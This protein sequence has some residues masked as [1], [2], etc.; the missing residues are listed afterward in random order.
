M[1]SINT[2]SNP[3]ESRQAGKDLRKTV[4]RKSHG[5]WQPSK[6]RTDP[7]TLIHD[8]EATRLKDLL[9][10]RHE[11]MSISAFTFYRGAALLM[12]SDLATTQSTGI[13]CQICGDA[14]IANF[15]GFG[16]PER[17]LIYDINDF[18]ET[19]AGPWEWDV[20]RFATSI[21]ICGR[22]RGFSASKRTAIVE[23][24]VKKYRE[25]MLE[26]AQMN[27]ID[28]WYAHL[29]VINVLAT[30]N[31][32][33]K[34][35]EGKQLGKTLSK[36]FGKTSERAVEKLTTVENG[37]RHIVSQPPLI[38]PLAELYPTAKADKIEEG[39]RNLLKSYKKSLPADRR[40]LI[41]GYHLSDIGRK[42]V[43]VGSV[44]TRAWI[45][46]FTG[47]D[48]N[49]PLVLQIKEAD[50]S[51]L[52]AYQHTSPY[53]NHGQRVVEGQRLMQA[54][55]D[56]LL[57]W[58]RGNNIS[59]ETNDFYVRQLWD[60]KTSTNLD[61]ITERELRAMASMSA[62][63]LA[64]A[65][66]RSGNRFAIAG[67]LGKSSSFDEALGKFARTYADL[68]EQDYQRFVDSLK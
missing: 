27:T 59:N 67:Y 44:G 11:R 61:T 62:W 4:S 14:H 64:R 16:S 40:C 46:V 68:N 26:F 2:L 47:R 6:D 54:S 29:D 19:L 45:A 43:G 10:I 18:D 65:H 39:V 63:T 57:G 8:Q 48:V 34:K 32:Q 36:A 35:R 3:E 52:E 20:K 41:D 30:W 7:L 55:S 13:T 22:D 33:L 66:A 31:V 49:D 12:A 5:D 56:I 53:A 28:V 15:G 51:V 42:V 37:Q 17:H 21:E 24:A 38:V 1:P 9:P 60:W 25:T 23:E 58:V 50:P